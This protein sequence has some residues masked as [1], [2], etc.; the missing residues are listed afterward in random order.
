MLSEDAIMLSTAAANGDIEVRAN[1]DR[2]RGDFRKII[3]G[4]NTTLD[5]IVEP[6]LVV[7]DAVYAINSAAQEIS[8][9]NNDLSVRTEQQA[10]SLE[11]TTVNIEEL[12]SKVNQNSDNAKQ[13]TFLANAASR[14]AIQG[15]QSVDEIIQMMSNLND[16]AK[17]IEVIT[18]V[19]DSIAFQTNILALNAAVE[20]ARAG[21]QGRGFAVVASEVRNLAQRSADAA[22]EIKTLINDSVSQT[23]IG[24]TQVEA[25]G[26]TMT[27][28]VNSVQKVN[29]IIDAISH[30]TAEQSAGIRQVN[31]AINK[32]DEVTQQNSALVEEAAA[33]AESLAEQALNLSD[34]VSVFKLTHSKVSSTKKIHQ[35]ESE[36]S[37]NEP[38]MY[39]VA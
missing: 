30:A 17:K 27:E 4:V 16:S 38:E 32:I 35:F 10:S 21:E 8:N 6:I 39:A 34:A 15:G 13:A 9:G 22:K 11:E 20:A 33:A 23:F 1:V 37:V 25:A 14:I 36:D 18:S 31:E 7:K 19:I 5:V 26:K 24:A 29:E 3:K 28:I 2:H 12:T